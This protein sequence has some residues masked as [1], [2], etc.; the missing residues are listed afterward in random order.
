MPSFN[1]QMISP[2][3]VF[4][5]FPRGEKG[6]ACNAA[7]KGVRG[8]VWDAV[9]QA[10]T[11]PVAAQAE[12]VRRVASA[13]GAK[14]VP[15]PREVVA[16]F[17]EAPAGGEVADYTALSTD[18][19]AAMF[20]FQ[21]EGFAFGVQ[22]GGRCMICDEMGL[23]KTV[24]AIAIAAHYRRDWP[25]LVIA[26]S[27]LRGNW[28]AEIRRWLPDVPPYAV[29]TVC[30][31]RETPRALVTV[32]SYDLVAR[33][34][35]VPGQYQT[36]IA[37]ESH[38]LKNPASIRT[39]KVV[40]LLQ[41][42]R[43]AVLLTGTP[44]LSRPIELY[45]QLVAL[46]RPILPNLVRFGR[47]Y[48]AAFRGPHGW[49]YS[50]H[51][52]L[53]ELHALLAHTVMIRRLKAQVL[54]QLPA[55]HR[56]LV[57]IAP[58]PA[59]ADQLADAR[60]EMSRNG[61]GGNNNTFGFD[62]NDDSNGSG[63]GS[64]SN[65][66]R[67]AVTAYFNASAQ[68]KVRP[69][70]EYLRRLLA[71]RKK[72]LVFGHHQVMLDGIEALFRGAGVPHIRID[73]G[74][75]A[76]QRAE[77]VARFQGDAAC[78]AALLSLTAAGTGLTL[79]AAD[80]V[81][82]A[83]LYWTPGVLMQAEDRAHRI[84]QT[85]DVTVQYLV[86][87]G[88]ID[89]LIWRLIESKMHVL[90][91]TMDG[92]AQHLDH[93][94]VD[95]ASQ[96]LAPLMHGAPNV[97]APAP[98]A[99]PSPQ[100]LRAMTEARA[101]GMSRPPPPPSSSASTPLRGGQR[102]LTD[103]FAP[104]GATTGAATA[105]TGV[106]PRVLALDSDD[107]SEVEDVPDDDSSLGFGRLLPRGAACSRSSVVVAPATQ[108]CAP[109]HDDLIEIDDDGDSSNH[110]HHGTG[111]PGVRD[112]ADLPPLWGTG[113]SGGTAGAGGGCAQTCGGNGYDDDDVDQDESLD[114]LAP[115]SQLWVPEPPRPDGAPRAGAGTGEDD[116]DEDDLLLSDSS[117][118][119]FAVT[120]VKG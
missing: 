36:I 105:T 43:H 56:Q 22:R 116:G 57:P 65:D 66:T 68:A 117:M 26:P 101:S 58:D 73:G 84:G 55:K 19:V 77:A 18:L 61:S 14:V 103:F 60:A 34:A 2:G 95:Q 91:R 113:A 46:G 92:A 104:A 37:D 25:L 4:A 31:A 86:A 21:L 81:V 97:A 8:A 15:V 72:F 12:V 80:I 64:G 28:A 24:Q 17:A 119:S 93:D 11:F 110:D 118:P 5:Q 30:S 74:T 7:M 42:A 39:R 111:T 48:C 38:Y 50:G 67:P 32:V 59:F 78:H 53:R 3:T 71:L 54:A 89:D 70:C 20:P 27:S 83:E 44:A 90:G 112:V 33:L 114:D 94:T 40:P 49:D 98:Q 82:F 29:Q 76:L 35:L 62:S 102:M 109:D 120:V 99:G 16:A 6:R 45:P 79:N 52:N 75:P 115:G 96:S 51:S 69:V 10:W 88:T 106:R 100:L 85:R 107:E 87:H 9:E 23:G 41:A 63:N 47:R 108:A 1:L 13:A